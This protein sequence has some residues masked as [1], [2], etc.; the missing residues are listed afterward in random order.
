MYLPKTVPDDAI[1]TEAYTGQLGE[2]GAHYDSGVD[3][4]GVAWYA[5]TRGF[6]AGDGLTIVAT[7]PNGHVRIPSERDRAV[8]FVQ[9]NGH[10]LFAVVGAGVLLAYYLIVWMQVGRDPLRGVIFPR[11][12]PPVGYSP[13]SM[14]YIER[15][16]YDNKVFVAALVNLAVNGHLEIDERG[17]R[18]TVRSRSSDSPLAPG[19]RA[20]LKTLLK[21]GDEIVLEPSQHRTI[22]GAPLTHIKR[23]WRPTTNAS[24]SIPTRVTA[25]PESSFHCCCLGSACLFTQVPAIS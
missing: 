23:T 3:S 2:R 16:G 20:L 17:G 15:M 21:S 12:E 7:W 5:T 25:L 14:R 13:A 19:E 18:Y 1:H 4:D 9:D 8:W 22:A 24:I 6:A 11:Y 10:L